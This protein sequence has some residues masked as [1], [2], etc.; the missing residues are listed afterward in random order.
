MKK[1][2][3]TIAFLSIFTL[4]KGQSILGADASNTIFSPPLSTRDTTTSYQYLD[5]ESYEM[6]KSEADKDIKRE[7]L[8]SNITPRS[9]VDEVNILVG[10]TDQ[11]Q[12]E[13]W[14]FFVDQKKLI[15]PLGSATSTIQK[16]Y[17]IL[18]PLQPPSGEI[19]LVVSQV[20]DLRLALAIPEKT[21]VVPFYKRG[22]IRNES[23]GSPRQS[24]LIDRISFSQSGKPLKTLQSRF[25]EVYTISEK[26]PIT[27]QIIGDV[28]S[29]STEA[30]QLV[31]VVL[32]E[33]S[34]SIQPLTTEQPH[35]LNAEIEVQ[36]PQEEEKDMHIILIAGPGEQDLLDAS[37]G[38]KS[39]HH[40]IS[41]QL[42]PA[43]SYPKL[44]SLF[45]QANSRNM[46]G[47]LAVILIGSVLTVLMTYRRQS[48]RAKIS[49][50]VILI[51]QA[52]VLLGLLFINT[53]S[54]LFEKG[55]IRIPGE[56]ILILRND[57]VETEAPTLTRLDE[58]LE[59]TT[60]LS[61]SWSNISP[62]IWEFMLRKDVSAESIILQ[63]QR[64]IQASSPD[65]QYLASI[66]NMISVYPH[67][68]QIITQFP[69]PLLPQ[70]LT[71][72]P[73]DPKV[74]A[75]RSTEAYLPLEKSTHLTR[76]VRNERYAL[77]PFLQHPA[78]YQRVVRV[79]HPEGIQK[80]I[81][82]QSI[83]LFDEP[84]TKLWPSLLQ[85]GYRILPKI[86]TESMMLLVN[87]KSFFLKDAA[88]VRSLQKILQSPRIL[89]TSYFQY[90]QL[91]NQFAP[92][93]VVGYDPKLSRS[94]D[95]GE[96]AQVLSD[97]RQEKQRD[98][99]V[100]TLQ[101]PLQ[102]EEV[103]KAIQRELELAGITVIASEIN[104]ESYEQALMEQSADLTLL[105]LDFEIGDVGPFLDA[106][107]DSQSAFNNTYSNPQVDELISQSRVQLNHVK[108][109]ELLQ[110][111]MKIIVEEDPAGIPLLFKRSFIAI[112]PP[113]ETTRWERF[114]QWAVLGWK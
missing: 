3:H 44:T 16:T 87:R 33:M 51:V 111:I 103:A 80:L 12:Q 89:Q 82:Q 94:S 102:E 30:L 34:Q 31:S 62:H 40:I 86:N 66:K 7:L 88:V 71:K 92:P 29:D 84:E 85:N 109:L 107:I 101:Y 42:Q 50:L 81:E 19:L 49:S 54:A 114:L 68:L 28:F 57:T 32:P 2:I 4:L 24:I 95:A 35:R 91:A 6:L 5:E 72:V 9:V 77:L 38:S 105:P 27:I 45:W 36:A 56:E 96:I 112:K 20:S 73:L 61:T 41:F 22:E 59:L 1:W 46:T 25:L 37:S 55:L 65:R 78:Y 43:G 97:L 100:L 13:V 93:G 21:I 67:K 106:L 15:Y 23:S 53:S 39:T 74:D 83:D 17:S 79:E 26:D 75:D 60:A 110:Q 76:S 63:F 90:G 69:D 98:E 8:I 70:K 99:I 108:R 14:G 18:P 47:L 113:P 52:G 11:P 104:H 64:K 58:D 10:S 48:T